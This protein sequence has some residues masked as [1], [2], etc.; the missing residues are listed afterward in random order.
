MFKRSAIPEIRTQGLAGGEQDFEQ[1]GFAS[2]RDLFG[3]QR[4][5]DNRF[6]GRQFAVQLLLERMV[7][8]M[9]L[10]GEH[11]FPRRPD[12]AQLAEAQAS[13]LHH[14]RSKDA[15]GKRASFV[16]LTPPGRGIQHRARRVSLWEISKAVPG[17][18]LLGIK[19]AAVRVAREGGMQG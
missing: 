6:Q 12:V 1:R 11:V 3:E 18:L 16:Q 19:S 10:A 13:V 2:D 15:A 9:H 14:R 17:T 8:Q 4:P 5:R 7:F